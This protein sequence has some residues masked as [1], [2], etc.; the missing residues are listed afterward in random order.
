MNLAPLPGRPALRLLAALWLALAASGAAAEAVQAPDRSRLLVEAERA[1]DEGRAEDA[2]AIYRSLVADAPDDPHLQAHLGR[3]LSLADRYG[4]AVTALERAVAGGVRDV[5]TLLFLGSALWES[6]QAEAADPIFTE[7]VAAAGGTGAEPLAQHQLGRL[8]LWAG[9][10]EAAVA[11]LERAA[12][13]RPRAPD[14]RLDLARALAGAGRNEEAVAA[15]RAVLELLPDSHHARWGLAQA[16][17]RLGRR[18]EAAAEL[19]AYRDLYEASQERTRRFMLQRAELDRGWHLI[20]SG[21]PAEAEEV[22]RALIAAHGEGVDPLLGLARALAGQGD[23]AAAAAALE[24]A[25]SLAPDRE[26]L[27]RILAQE[28]LA[29][30]GRP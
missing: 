20:G 21:R 27:R 1:L 14:P 29:A 6:G 12:A 15:F 24:R 18:E 13:L 10:S 7:A 11:P 25:V 23:H 22:F 17:L 19:A 2:A 4:E 28:R 8:R 5:R 30:E 9:R 16:L 26:D 3:A